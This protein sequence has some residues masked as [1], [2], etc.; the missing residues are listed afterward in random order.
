MMQDKDLDSNVYTY[1][2]LSLL[3]EWYAEDCTDT[4]STFRMKQ[5]YALKT[6]SHDTDTPTY[7]EE[8]SKRGVR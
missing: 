1:D 3:P 4:T 7:I 8:L 2:I 5:Y 6:Q